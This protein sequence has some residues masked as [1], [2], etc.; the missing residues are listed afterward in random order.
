MKKTLS[1]LVAVLAIAALAIIGGCKSPTGQTLTPAQV[2]AQVC[3]ASEAAITTL[4]SMTGLPAAASNDLA[5]AAPIVDSVCS[6]AATVDSTNLQSLAN[7]AIPAAI[8]II[9]V[10]NLSVDEQNKIIFDLGAAQFLINTVLA[11]QTGSV[12]PA[13]STLHTPA[14][15]AK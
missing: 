14:S 1:C 5:K 11:A 9:K 3:P 7:T 8:S 2:A 15:A 10:T 4:Q 13:P 6:V 12:A